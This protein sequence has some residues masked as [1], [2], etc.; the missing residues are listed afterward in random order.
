MNFSVNVATFFY[1]YEAVQNSALLITKA[2]TYLHCRMGLPVY[3]SSNI[4]CTTL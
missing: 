4:G 3:S 1:K 2:W